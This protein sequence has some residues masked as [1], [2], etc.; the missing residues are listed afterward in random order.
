MEN[1]LDAKYWDD[2]YREQQTGWD[3][4]SPSTPLKEYIDHLTDVNQAILVPGCGNGYEVEYLLQKGFTNVTVIDLAPTLTCK[5]TEKLARW[6]GKELTILTGNFFDHS[7]SYDLIL[8]QTFFCA[9]DPS[10]RIDYVET[11]FRLL[12]PGGRLAGVLFNREFPGGPPFGGSL[13]EY[14]TLFSPF[15]KKS[16]E[17]CNNSIPSRMGTELFIRLEKQAG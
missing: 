5:L 3:I 1:R 2:R 15:A 13:Q 14:E 17:P 4:G 9:L 6:N 10:L 16:I 7:G 12:K 11:M 8:E